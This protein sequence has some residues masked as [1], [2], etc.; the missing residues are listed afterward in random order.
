MWDYA[1][2]TEEPKPGSIAE[3]NGQK[4]MITLGTLAY[5]SDVAGAEV[6]TDNQST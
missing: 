6:G 2:A 4:V 3:D 5:T 1:R